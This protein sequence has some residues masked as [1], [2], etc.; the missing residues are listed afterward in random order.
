MTDNPLLQPPM[1]P[2]PMPADERPLESWKEIAAYLKRT[3]RTAKRWEQ[4]EGLPVRRH[5][6]Q[7]R[8]SV[9][10]YPSELDAWVVSRQT[11]METGAVMLTPGARWRAVAALL[12]A[13]VATLASAG[14]PARPNAT[15]QGPDVVLR[16][17]WP[18]PVDILGSPTADGRLLSFVDWSTGDL[19]VREIATGKNRRLTH[20]GTWTESDEYAEFSLI[21]PDAQQIAYAWFNGTRYELRAMQMDGN[22][23]RTLH[24][25]DE[26]VYVQPSSWTPDGKKVVAVFSRRDRTQQIVLV[27]VA[28]G[29]VQ[30]L[31]SFDW[32]YPAKPSLSPDG[33]FIAY[34]FAP[35]EE[36]PEQ[37]VFVLEVGGSREARAVEHP[38]HDAIVGWAP[39]GEHV[40]FTS[41]RTGTPSLF[42]QR[43]VDGRKI[44]EPAILKRD[45]GRILPVGVTPGGSLFFSTARGQDVVTA[46]FDALTGALSETKVAVQRFVG[47]NSLPSWSHDGRFLAYLSGRRGGGG[48]PVLIIHSLDTGEEREI[49]P[50]LRILPNPRLGKPQW[51]PNG[52]SILVIGRDQKGRL[53]AFQINVATSSVTPLLLLEDDTIGRAIAWADG[54]KSIVFIRGEED[55]VASG[56]V[57]DNP[58]AVIRRELASGKETI[59]YRS[60]HIHTGAVS[61][62]GQLVA[63]STHDP[64]AFDAKTREALQARFLVVVPVAGGSARTILDVGPKEEIK[65]IAWTGD[66]KDIFF[67]KYA[68]DE[69]NPDYKGKVWRMRAEGGSPRSHRGEP[70]LT[71]LSFPT[72]VLPTL[73]FHPDGKRIAYT[74]RTGAEEAIWVLEN[75]L[76]TA[77]AA[78]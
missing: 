49:S 73:T 40:L 47:Q 56:V 39:D 25:N 18:N 11:Q 13:V 78:K 42:S 75:F 59:L 38:A 29:A 31:K 17:V 68:N 28:D 5:M 50:K 6:H 74:G 46:E 16:R 15:A 71:Q 51:A 3:E 12:I 9:Y 70:Q 26:L 76:P 66:S 45:I 60:R 30:V 77:R 14:S 8:A 61:P 43:V 35:Q 65:G 10:A 4:S 1:K 52:R 67:T 7:S 63:I 53:G 37:D 23:V 54:G 58:I 22:G 48:G 2:A 32:R 20:K 21:S 34:S 19:A 36:A 72:S 24:K 41:D 33:R 55:I 44:G 57:S 62:D 64:A 69:D 27:N